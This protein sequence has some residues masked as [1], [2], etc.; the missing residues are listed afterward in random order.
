[1]CS[2]YSSFLKMKT[3]L[4]IFEK[5]KINILNQCLN[6]QNIIKIFSHYYINIFSYSQT[7]MT[8]SSVCIFLYIFPKDTY[9]CVVACRF[10]TGAIGDLSASTVKYDGRL[11]SKCEG[12][13]ESNFR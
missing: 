6:Y 7:V 13:S 2:A 4:R 10:T 5:F 12:Y 11:A 8:N 1:M 9:K 3:V